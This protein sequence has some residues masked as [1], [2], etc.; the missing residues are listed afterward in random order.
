M[1]LHL[2]TALG[3]SRSDECA[4]AL[5]LRDKLEKSHRDSLDVIEKSHRYSLDELENE[6]RMSQDSIERL[7]RAAA[8]GV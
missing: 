4:E 8:P 7:R 3:D 1:A 5:V 6:D 2:P